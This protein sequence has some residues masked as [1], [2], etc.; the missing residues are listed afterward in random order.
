MWKCPQCG[1]VNLGEAAACPACGWAAV[2]S[3]KSAESLTGELLRLLSQGNKLEA[4]KLYKDRTGSTLL[5]SKYAVEALERG[6]QVAAMTLSPLL[7][8]AR[9]CGVAV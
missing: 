3:D 1:R 4:V 9:P 2:A 6:E 8:H 5:I 7:L